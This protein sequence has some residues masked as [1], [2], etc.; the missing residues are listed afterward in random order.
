MRVETG[1]PHLSSGVVTAAKD[2]E[3]L[4]Y[5]AV[6][7]FETSHEPFLP[8]VLAAE[9]TGHIALRTGL[10]ISFPR[11]PMVVANAAWDLQ[12]YSNGRFQLGLG[13]QV[14]GHNERRFSVPWSPPA[15][16]MREYVLALRAIW[17]TWATGERLNFVGEHYT[18]TLMTPN[19]TPER[20]ANPNIPIYVS[21]LGPAMARVAGEVCDGLLLHPM[22]SYRYI[23]DVILPAVEAGAQRAGR[24]LSDIELLWGGFSAMGDTD[25]ELRQ[26]KLNVARS[27]SFYGSTR[28]YGPA[29][30]IHGWKDLNLQLHELS[31]RGKWNEMMALVTD[32]MVETLAETGTPEEVARK[33]HA[34]YSPFCSAVMWSARGPRPFA[35][36]RTKGILRIL[37]APAP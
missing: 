36:E 19:F 17:N 15:P 22:C 1:L 26:A 34:R 33:L 29:L 35:P 9:H 4:G 31:L 28:T 32:E 20:I 8:L 37:Q 25:D 5:D 27:I 7:S 10:A 21:A 3:D 11:S 14:K 6:V 13:T 23:T 16:R 12:G 2:A 24:K 18:F 30:A